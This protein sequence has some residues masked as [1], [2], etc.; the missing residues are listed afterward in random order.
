MIDKRRRFR[1][2]WRSRAVIDDDLEAELEFHLEMRAQEL[3]RQGLA[4]ATARREAEREFGEDP[5]ETAA[6]ELLRAFEEA[7]IREA[8]QTA[9]QELRRAESSGDAAKVIEAEA[10]CAKLS[11]RLASLG[12]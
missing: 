6:D 12:A 2:P 4:P 10:S 7:Y 11:A 9:V 8:Y 1:L 3:A 5:P